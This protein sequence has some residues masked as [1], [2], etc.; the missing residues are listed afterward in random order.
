MKRASISLALLVVGAVACSGSSSS[1]PSE[2]SS[3]PF[4]SPSS[5]TV[6][7]LVDLTSGTGVGID[8]ISHFL[9]PVSVAFTDASG[10]LLATQQ[11]DLSAEPNLSSGPCHGVGNYRMSAP[12]KDLYQVKVEGK[13]AGS[14]SLT[15]LQSAHYRYD[16]HASS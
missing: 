6:R 15:D 8:C 10:T 4:E 7:G 14:V 11:V 16:I 2:G 13:S 1:S 12:Q 9:H 3:S 5:I